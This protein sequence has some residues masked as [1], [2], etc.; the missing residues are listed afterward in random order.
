[1]V[2]RGDNTYGGEF[3]IQYQIL[4]ED[5]YLPATL[6]HTHLFFPSLLLW[7]SICA[8]KHV[9]NPSGGVS[10]RFISNPQTSQI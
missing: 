5:N 2:E 6:T 4:G 8:G 10:V 9:V 1:M 3:K 7:T